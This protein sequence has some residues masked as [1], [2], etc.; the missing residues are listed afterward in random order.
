MLYF[1]G[2]VFQPNVY[3]PQCLQ[4]FLN[5]DDVFRLCF[6]AQ[7]AQFQFGHLLFYHALEVH[8]LSFPTSFYG[9]HQLHLSKNLN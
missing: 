6:A 1:T 4:C 2:L 7:K 3:V 9:S 8:T 5:H